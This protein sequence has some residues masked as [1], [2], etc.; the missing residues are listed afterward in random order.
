MA[1]DYK[2]HIDHADGLVRPAALLEARRA[3]AE[4]RLDEAGLAK[5]TDDA[6][7]EVA[8]VQRR[9]GMSAVTDGQYRRGTWASVLYDGMEGFD[10]VEG[11][12]RPVGSPLSDLLG[13]AGSLPDSPAVVAKLEAT[14]RLAQAE[15][16]YLLGVTQRSTGVAL[17]A[18]GFVAER[19]FD[20][21]RT[22]AA[23]PAPE[24]VGA[25]LAAILRTEIQALAAEGVRHVQLANPGYA[26]A[27]SRAGRDRLSAH[28]IDPDV[29][30]DRM[31][32][33]DRASIEALG[34]DDTFR[35]SLDITTGGAVDLT[36]GYDP[37]AV[38]RFFSRL[39]FYRVQVEHTAGA[40]FPLSSVPSGRVLA[41]GVVDVRAAVTPPVEELLGRIDAVTSVLDVDDIAISTN[42]S[43]APTVDA[44]GQVSWTEQANRLQLVE[45]VARYYWGNEL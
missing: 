14:G 4:G 29:L 34:T 6:I 1:D 21:S 37:D 19:S 31:A 33:A 11:A 45:M 35:V 15:A 18:A 28:G 42:G 8:K 7:A 39:P 36:G 16:T 12:E 30:L 44:P 40:D 43:F 26:L 25:E 20:P 2:Y 9:I 27:I 32:E 17:P 3:R 23:Y 13:E 5:V 22:P 41:L 38:T 24:L 10:G